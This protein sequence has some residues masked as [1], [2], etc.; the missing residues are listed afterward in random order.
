MSIIFNN[1]ESKARAID[2]LKATLTIFV[3]PYT[4]PE[5][6]EQISAHVAHLDAHIAGGDLD[7]QTK[8]HTANDG[9]MK[10]TTVIRP[11][12]GGVRTNGH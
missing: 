8:I 6:R 11:V 4:T 12:A 2:W 3:M 1:R 10:I 5:I 9:T 7:A